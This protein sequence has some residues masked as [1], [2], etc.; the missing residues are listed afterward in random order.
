MMTFFSRIHIFSYR[1]LLDNLV[2]SVCLL[3]FCNACEMHGCDGCAC[4]A[5]CACCAGCAGCAKCLQICIHWWNIAEH[6]YIFFKNPYVFLYVFAR[7][8][9]FV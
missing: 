7:Q 9:G 6:D 2:L 3:C 5:C 4:C 8:F 1:C